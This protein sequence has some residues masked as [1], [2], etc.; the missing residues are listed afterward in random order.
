V[1]EY[2]SPFNLEEFSLIPDGGGLVI[3]AEPAL[4]K[5]QQ[6]GCGCFWFKK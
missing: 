3:N 5:E 1:I 2:F 6:Y 4:V